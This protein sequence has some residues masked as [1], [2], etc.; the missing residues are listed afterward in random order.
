MRSTVLTSTKRRQSVGLLII[1][2]ATMT[3]SSRQLLLYSLLCS[4]LVSMLFIPGLTG[5]FVFDDDSNIVKNQAI[6]MQTLD[7]ASIYQVAFGPQPG[8]ITRV[9]PTLTFAFDYWRG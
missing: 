7:A 9:L 2:M 3:I 8:G 5:G 4:A 6:R 1:C